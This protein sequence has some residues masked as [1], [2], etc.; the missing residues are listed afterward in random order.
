[1]FPYENL[2]VYQKAKAYN[3]A[4]ESFALNYPKLS[5]IRKDQLVRASFRDHNQKLGTRHKFVSI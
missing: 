5:K 3:Y 1:M 2:I 4:V